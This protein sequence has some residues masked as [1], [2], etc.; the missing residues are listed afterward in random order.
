MTRIN[1]VK[2]VLYRESSRHIN[3]IVKYFLDKTSNR[4][5]SDTDK[6][7][8]IFTTLGLDPWAGPH[9]TALSGGGEQK[10]YFS[11]CARAGHLGY[12]QKKNIFASNFLN[13]GL[14]LI[15]FISFESS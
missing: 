4:Y 14:I 1:S 5:R 3:C 13:N 2:N 12:E 11:A 6:D 8:A 7:T 10:F 9:N 15:N